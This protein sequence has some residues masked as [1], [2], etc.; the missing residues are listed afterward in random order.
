MDAPSPRVIV[1]PPAPSGG[2]RVRVDGTTL[3]VAYRPADVIE[4]LRRAG[5]DPDQIDLHGPDIEWRGGGPDIWLPPD[6]PA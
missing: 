4:F 1:Q 6:T 5:A 2:R 3:G